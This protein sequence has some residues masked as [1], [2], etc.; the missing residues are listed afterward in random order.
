[1]IISL[2][3]IAG[4]CLD[5]TLQFSKGNVTNEAQILEKAVVK[6]I[7]KGVFIKNSCDFIFSYIG[8]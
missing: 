5:K 1:V 3:D 7:L 4:Y 2:L 6:N 8:I